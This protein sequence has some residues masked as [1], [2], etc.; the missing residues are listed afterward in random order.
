VVHHADGADMLMGKI[1]GPTMLEDFHR[2]PWRLVRHARLLA[3]LQRRLNGLQAPDWL[4]AKAGVPG[5][6]SV[7]HLDLHPMNVM[8]A[9]DGPVVIDWTNA[10]RGDASFDAA[11]SS[12]LMSTAE[13]PN[14]AERLAV[15][16]FVFSFGLFRGRRLVKRSTRA[17]ATFR[18]DD[19]NTTDLERDR[20]QRLTES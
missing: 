8:L 3:G 11:M 14:V 1:V 9:D 15:R 4:A 13:L 16:L 5:G 19:P 6:D 17:A 7:L 12:V 20:L 18:L 2:R 10:T